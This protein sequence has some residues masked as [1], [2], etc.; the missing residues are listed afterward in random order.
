MLIKWCQQNKANNKFCRTI[1][2]DYFSQN[3]AEKQVADQQFYP[4]GSTIPR[5]NNVAIFFFSTG[6]S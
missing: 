5:I 6:E 1:R 4:E 2:K 3:C